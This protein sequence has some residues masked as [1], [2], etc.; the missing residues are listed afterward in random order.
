ME[1]KVPILAQAAV[2]ILLTVA[3]LALAQ[4]ASSMP[5]CDPTFVYYPKNIQFLGPA[6]SVQVGEVA[7]DTHH[8]NS[9]A[10]LHCFETGH[11]LV[12][13]TFAHNLSQCP[14]AR[15]RQFQLPRFRTAADL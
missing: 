1:H 6:Q 7:I 2:A 10:A 4:D 11:H 15:H 3:P 14:P 5:Q 8:Q 12:P 13:C 9:A